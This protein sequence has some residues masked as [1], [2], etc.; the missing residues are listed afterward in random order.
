MRARALRNLGLLWIALSLVAA[1]NVDTPPLAAAAQMSAP[2][3]LP[4]HFGFGIAANE[5]TMSNWMPQSGIPWDYTF[6]FIAGGVGWNPGGVGNWQLWSPPNG[7]FP[8]Y[9]AQLA[10]A[11]GAIAEDTY[12]MM[13]VSNGPCNACT[14]QRERDLANLDSTSTM[15]AYYADYVKFMQRL[16]PGTYDGV[17]GYGGTVIV[18]VEPD[19]SGFADQAVN[20]NA[21]Y[22]HGHCTAEGNDPTFL[23]ASV[24]NSGITDVAGYADNFQGFS[25]ALAHIRDLYAPNVIL[26]AHI[27]NWAIRDIGWSPDPSL[28]ITAAAT[29]AA[30]FV[31]AIGAG[32][33]PG[34]TSNYDLLFN[35]PSDWDAEYLSATTGVSYW[36]DRL[37]VAY[38]NF[39][40]WEQYVNIA[41]TITGRPMMA[42]FVPVGNQYFQT[43]NNS[44]R[45][46]QDNRA[47]YFFS[48]VDELANSGLIG[49]IFSPGTNT[50]TTYE[51]ASTDGITNPPSFCNTRG[52]SSG[53]ICNNHASWFT[54]DDG[55]FL[56][57][58]ATAYYQNPYALGSYNS[59]LSGYFNNGRY[60]AITIY[61]AATAAPV[62]YKCCL[63][64]DNWQLFVP[65]SS[66]ATGGYRIYF[67][68]S[69]ASYR[70]K[71]YPGV[72]DW[73]SA[74]CV[75]A[76]SDGLS[77]TIPASGIVSG[78]V[79][80]F[81]SAADINGAVVYAYD[82]SS[83]A[84]A[85]WASSGD[86]VT[87]RY[88]MSLT[89]GTSYKFQVHAGGVYPDA[90]LNG[91][92]SFATATPT[93]A[94]GTA[95]F[96]ILSNAS[97]SGYVKDASSAADL[98][99]VPVY[100][101]NAATGAF[102]SW[103][104]SGATGHYSIGVPLGSYKVM[105]PADSSHETLWADGSWNWGESTAV[106]APATRNFSARAAGN[107]SG[108]ATTLGVPTANYTVTAYT[109]TASR[110][111][112]SSATDGGGNYSIKVA[113]SAASGWQYKM[114]FTP[115][116][117]TQASIRWYLNQT[118]SNWPSATN[119][120]APA[121]NIN[122][123]TPA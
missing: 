94:P 25:L 72:D 53:Q 59:E 14:D 83:G 110:N 115:P 81:G 21:L 109:S 84:F 39:H 57:M 118:N 62:M 122:Q 101:Y 111:A 65:P 96:S 88:S 11:H 87:G 7:R 48:H 116:S 71:W 32:G 98:P 3:G 74:S 35:D 69:D 90:W 73:S 6:G 106:A 44:S 89:P 79:K 26:A 1:L 63:A 107:V 49:V 75:S 108:R 102:V 31:Y 67:T 85:G 30:Q 66:C 38:P 64:V 41:S 119:V 92:S 68:P 76:S 4:N 8:I 70:P 78:Y 61:N 46:W 91:A 123:D 10:A 40:R 103:A 99:W 13:V 51:D 23:H 9:M 97:I 56:R 113:A 12:Q 80:D 112:G 104:S 33:A 19:L 117:G 121:S 34:G 20:N 22:C 36:W 105:T 17:P 2:A 15:S 55:G 27:S 42:W 93:A 95:N 60:G 86:A 50:Q 82:A 47:E 54:D 77:M 120:T 24:A 45:H 114:R 52:I 37:N 100:A 5:N 43:V 18:H 16:G 28:D 29:S 58:S